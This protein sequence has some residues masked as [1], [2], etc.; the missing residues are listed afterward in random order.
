MRDVRHADWNNS[1]TPCVYVIE[2]PSA[3]DLV[4]ERQEG[5]ALQVA[6]HQ[7]RIPCRY[8][9]ATSKEAFLR[10]LKLITLQRQQDE[11]QIALHISCHGNKDGIG[12]T[13]GEF[14]DWAELRDIL[15]NFAEEALA[16]HEAA[17]ISSIVLC[18][19]SCFGLAASS[20]NEHESR[21]FMSLVA[22]N[23]SALWSDCLISFLSFY[24]LFLIKNLSIGEA[25]NGMNAASATGSMFQVVDHSNELR[26]VV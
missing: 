23:T 15:V 3:I 24:N 4:E 12:L 19:S 22:P 9:L 7:A 10:S 20:M 2:S 5:R 21:P 6:L 1:N 11:Q 13:S 16:Y 26:K 25:V 17:K 14:M 8:Y 18:M